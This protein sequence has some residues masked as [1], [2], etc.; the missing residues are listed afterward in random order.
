M[1]SNH[2]DARALR[3]KLIAIAGACG[4]A[5]VPLPIRVEL[6]R[7]CGVRL[8]QIHRHISALRDI[9][10]ITTQRRSGRCFVQEGRP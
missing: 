3:A 2:P 9:G 8:R 5:G 1:S 10:A 4:S 6:A 7:I